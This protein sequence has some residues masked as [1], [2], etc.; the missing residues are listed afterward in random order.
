MPESWRPVVAYEGFYEVSARGLVR[1]VDRVFIRADG[2][3]QG[4]RGRLLVQSMS[5]RNRNYPSVSL[6]FGH[7]RA[8]HRL[9]AEAFLGPCPGQGFEVAHWNGRTG[10]NQVSNLR[11]ATISENQQDSIR[12]GTKYSPP[13][14]T[15]AGS[16]NQNAQLTWDLVRKMRLEYAA[17]GVGQRE[18]AKRYGI[19]KSQVQNI[20]SGRHWVDKLEMWSL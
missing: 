7:R 13:I 20:I 6:R 5:G 17:G 10:D 8:V 19:G 15:R 18:L 16:L 4:R 11:W 12:H 9:V 14:G 3:R 1:S 2:R